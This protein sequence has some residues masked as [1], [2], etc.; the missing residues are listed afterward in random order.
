MS[1]FCEQEEMPA[2]I[3]AA[4]SADGEQRENGNQKAAIRAGVG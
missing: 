3:P 4:P 2:G 1:V